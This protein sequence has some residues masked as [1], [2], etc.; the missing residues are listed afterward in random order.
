MVPAPGADDAAEALAVLG[1]ALDAAL[2]PFP[3]VPGDLYFL[4]NRRAVHG[5]PAFQPRYDGTD[6]WLLR[7]KT[8]RDIRGSGACRTRGGARVVDVDRLA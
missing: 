2:R 4:D 6:R 7:V 8:G 3:A 1:A 5:R